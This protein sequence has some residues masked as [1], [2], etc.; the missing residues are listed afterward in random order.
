MFIRYDLSYGEVVSFNP[1]FLESF[2]HK[3]MVNFN[4]RFFYICWDDHMFFILQLLR[5]YIMLI[6]LLL[7]TNTYIPEINATLSWCMILFIYYLSQFAFFL[8]DFSIYLYQWYWSV[9][10]FF[11]VCFFGLV[12]GWWWLQRVSGSA[13]SIVIFWKSFRRMAVNLSLNIW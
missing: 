10:L 13:S 2:C 6:N 7:L 3:G 4:K 5:W 12:S 8:K 1:H 11:V 9:I